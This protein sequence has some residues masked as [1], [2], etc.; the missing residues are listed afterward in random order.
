VRY[1]E[2][3]DDTSW[4][5]QAKCRGLTYLFFPTTEDGMKG[6]EVES[7]IAAPKAICD[8]C[9]VQRDCLDYA[10]R[11]REPHGVWGGKATRERLGGRR[12]RSAATSGRPVSNLARSGLW[13]TSTEDPM[14]G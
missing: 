4:M 7:R 8:E 10:I 1:R 11:W 5:S 3:D 9:P 2:R 13:A 12:G 6:S 14:M